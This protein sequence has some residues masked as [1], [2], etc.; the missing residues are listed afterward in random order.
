MELGGQVDIT[1]A[2]LNAN[3]AM[4]QMDMQ[5]AEATRAQDTAKK[6]ELKGGIQ[7]LGKGLNELAKRLDGKRVKGVQ[8]IKD[9]SGK[10]VAARI[11]R[12]DG[13]VDD[14]PIQ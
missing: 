10:M 1:N 4:K 3:A 12:G 7:E 14:V 9:A 2:T 5:Q 11:Q 6:D 8:K 13:S